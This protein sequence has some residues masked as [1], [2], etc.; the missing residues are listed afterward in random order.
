MIITRRQ[1][2]AS[3]LALGL[4]GCATSKPPAPAASRFTPRLTTPRLAPIPA[5]G[6]TPAQVAML[7]RRPDYNIYKTLA[8]HPELYAR[9]SGLGQYILNGSSL[10]PRHREM[11]ILRMGWLC[12]APYEWAQHARIAVDGRFLTEAEVHAIAEGPRSKAWNNFERTLLQ[13]ADEVRY[14]AMLSEATWQGLKTQYANETVLDALFTAAQYQL[15][16]MAL[17]SLGVQLDPGLAHRLP[18]DVDPPK[19]AYRPRT[20]PLTSPRISPRPV[21]QLSAEDKT[22]LAERLRPDG[23]VFNLYATLINFPKIYG[24]RARFGSYLQRDSGLD[25]KTRELCILRTAANLNCDYEWAH[26]DELARQAGWTDADVARIREDSGSPGWREGHAAVLSAADELRG[27]AFIS[28]ATWK[29][30]AANYAPQR[31]VEI[32]F[33]VGGYCMTA[34]A[35]RTLGIQLEPA[36]RA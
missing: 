25:P 14:E 34:A 19:L 16:S 23:T 1:M 21:V 18:V 2:G 17:N 13:A 22:L 36:F 27:E 3:A 24:P 28:D 15:V 9:W 5:E 31:L 8:V 35:I 29:T 20:P 11:L 10:P 12:Q 32:I 6:R 7:A 26:H 4:A 30:L 33:T